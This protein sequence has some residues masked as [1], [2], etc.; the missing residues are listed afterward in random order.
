MSACAI[1]LDTLNFPVALPCGAFIP[2]LSWRSCVLSIQFK[3]GM[4]TAMVAYQKQ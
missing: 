3:K 4:F 1:C 2:P